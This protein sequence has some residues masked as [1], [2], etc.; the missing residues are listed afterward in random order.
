[1]TTKKKSIRKTKKNL[2]SKEVKIK[3]ERTDSLFR[4]YLKLMEKYSS[5]GKD[6]SLTITGKK[7]DTDKGYYMMFIKRDETKKPDERI[8]VAVL[9]QQMQFEDLIQT[10]SEVLEGMMTS[11]NKINYA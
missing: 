4:D 11:G 8:Q 2:T 6:K 3:P 10:F 7:T 9:S 5:L 1:M